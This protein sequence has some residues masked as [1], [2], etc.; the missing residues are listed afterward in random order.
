[1]AGRYATRTDVAIEDSLADIA[2]LLRRYGAG[3]LVTGYNAQSGC[4]AFSMAGR[5]VKLF[6]P[7]PDRG[8]F[9]ETPKG[10]RRSAEQQERRY[11][12]ALRQRW[13]ALTLV[14]QAKLEA[15][16]VGISTLEREFLADLLLPEGHTV[17][18]ALLPSLEHSLATGQLPPLLSEAG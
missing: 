11:E 16:E 13:R 2:A 8:A 4:V 5:S 1:M 14:L 6:V 12:Q 9:A 7:M 18:A 15:C 10:K 17:G 3:E